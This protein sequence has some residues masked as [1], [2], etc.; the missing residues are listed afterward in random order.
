MKTLPHRLAERVTMDPVLAAATLALVAFGTVM[1]FTASAPVA[2]ESFGRA[3]FFLRRQA[4]RALI[5][6]LLM[7]LLSRFDCGYLR[8]RPAKALLFVAAALLLLPLLGGLGLSAGEKRGASRWVQLGSLGFQPVEFARLALVVYLADA[9][10]RKRETLRSYTRGFLPPFLIVS[11]VALMVLEQP[12]LGGCVTLGGMGLVMLYLAGA[13]AGHILLTVAPVLPLG[14]L[15]IALE[16]YRLRRFE[17]FLHPEADPTGSGW[18]V[19]QSTLAL[20]SGG[21]NG[22]G[23]GHSRQRALFLPD[24]HTDFILSIVG[25]EFGYLG[26]ALVMSLFLLFILRGMQTAA[27]ATDDFSFL[28]AAGLTASVALNWAVNVGVVCRLLPVTGLPLP[29]VSFGG[30]S[31]TIHLIGVGLLLSVSRTR[32]LRRSAVAPAASRYAGA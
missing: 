18:Q 23:L 28:L 26:I 5:G 11:V 22:V 10:S 29:F 31:L 27:K 32:R 3:D 30:S 25:E 13:R 20:A 17:G 21:L 9:L 6:I 2:A 15:A 12:S 14:A 19:W 7:F 1:V 4:G 8:G 16:P 24:A